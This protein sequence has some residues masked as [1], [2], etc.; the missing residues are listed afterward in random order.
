MASSGDL[1]NFSLTSSGASGCHHSTNHHRGGPFRGE[2]CGTGA[3]SRDG[4]P[5][6]L[7]FALSLAWDFAFW[8]ASRAAWRVAV[9]LTLKPVAT[10][11]LLSDTMEVAGGGRASLT[12]SADVM[13]PAPPAPF[14]ITTRH[15]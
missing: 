3:G 4:F 10:L 11:N 2:G 1:A 14:S 6:P 5:L 13:M 7:P 15:G 12:P 8:A 9:V